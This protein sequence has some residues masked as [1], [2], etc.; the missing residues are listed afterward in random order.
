MKKCFKCNI[1]KE[2]SE[3][4]KHSKMADGHVNK[5]KE[6]NKA[7]VIK[8]RIKRV[9][10]YRKY[11]TERNKLDHRKERSIVRNKIYR[12][13]NPKKYK[14]HG[15]VSRA[16]RSG[17]LIK[18]SSCE[19]CSSLKKLNAHHDDYNQPL[20]VRWLCSVCHSAWH[21]HNEAIQ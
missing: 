3:F 19:S 10:Y 6:C 2:L 21:K 11:D 5:C 12:K 7:D 13:T 17:K 15:I 20:E 18:G 1:E 14:A 16:I 4:Y 8:N 9:N